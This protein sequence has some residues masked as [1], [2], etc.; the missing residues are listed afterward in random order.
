MIFWNVRLRNIK[1][2]EIVGEILY[3][4]KG[5]ALE[6]LGYLENSKEY[7]VSLTAISVK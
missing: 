7:V 2:D 3:T 4:D 6:A 5:K 1:D